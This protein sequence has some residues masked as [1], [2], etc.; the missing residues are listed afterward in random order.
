MVGVHMGGD[1]LYP[2]SL[3]PGHQPLSGLRRQALPLPRHG[4]HPGDLGRAARSGDGGLYQ[5]HGPSVAQPH[6]PVAPLLGSVGG[7]AHHRGE[8]AD[9]PD[10]TAVPQR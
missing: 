4:D 10:D 8:S 1:G 3:Q 2:T 5:P 9:V 7:A 6:G